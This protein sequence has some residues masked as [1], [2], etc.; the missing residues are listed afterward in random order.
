MT[1]GHEYFGDIKKPTGHWSPVSYTDIICH[2]SHDLKSKTNP[3]EG[4]LNF[5]PYM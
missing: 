2:H 5:F 4:F 3:E 1:F